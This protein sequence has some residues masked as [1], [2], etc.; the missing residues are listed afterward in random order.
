MTL[1]GK[2]RV[3]PG[4]FFTAI[5]ILLSTPASATLQFNTEQLVQADSVDI[6]VPGWSV[7]SFVYWDGDGLKDLVVGEGGTTIPGKVRIYL[8]VG[9]AL[10]PQFS[11]YF[12]AQSEGADLSLP[13]AG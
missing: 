3:K 4:L 13:G 11:D 8:N 2:N 12:Y 6:E 10:E 5:L 1:P 7:P 9:T